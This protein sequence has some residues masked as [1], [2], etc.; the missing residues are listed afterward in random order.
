MFSAL[1]TLFNYLQL[2]LHGIDLLEGLC[3]DL[4]DQVVLLGVLLAV[5]EVDERL[6]GVHQRQ[7]L[8][9]T[10]HYDLLHDVW[11]DHLPDKQDRT[12]IEQ[13]FGTA[14]HCHKAKNNDSYFKW[15]NEHVQRS[16]NSTQPS[17][18]MLGRN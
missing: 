5:L 16:M 14:K 10:R 6:E 13:L 15:L 1:Q 8:D 12:F 7:M 17:Y 18:F 4:T 2:P 11:P 9:D 3:H